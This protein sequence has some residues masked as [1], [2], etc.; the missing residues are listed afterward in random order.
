MQNNLV[1]RRYEE[2][3]VELA[4]L[5]AAVYNLKNQ[6]M[7]TGAVPSNSPSLSVLFP[8]NSR[9]R[10]HFSTAATFFMKSSSS[11]RQSM[12]PI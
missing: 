12:T 3:K 2:G 7:S 11:M 4:K 9:K 10:M 1:N 6:E 8:E 5:M